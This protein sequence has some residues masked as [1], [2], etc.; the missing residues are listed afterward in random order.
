M[1]RMISY[2]TIGYIGFRFAAWVNRVEPTISNHDHLN[3][4][5][6]LEREGGGRKK[7]EKKE[8]KRKEGKEERKKGKRKEREK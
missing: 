5:V 2:D 3:S 6:F 8:R 7:E 1:K 4:Y